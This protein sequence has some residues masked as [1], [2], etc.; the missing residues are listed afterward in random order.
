[1]VPEA[2]IDL[3]VR[4]MAWWR[5][6][7]MPATALVIGNAEMQDTAWALHIKSL[8]GVLPIML[9]DPRKLSPADFKRYRAYADGYS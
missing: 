3:R 1:M 4:N 9:G 8:A 6:P 5:S 7:A 2:K